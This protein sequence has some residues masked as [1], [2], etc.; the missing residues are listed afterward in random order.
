[1]SYE[2]KLGRVSQ[3]K[4]QVYTAEAVLSICQC[5]V[6]CK[7]SL[8]K[9][10]D[11]LQYH[12]VQYIRQGGNITAMLPFWHSERATLHNAALL[13]ITPTCSELYDVVN[14]SLHSWP[15]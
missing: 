12:I 14:V 11:L 1:M 15:T 6:R 2:F 13:T 4:I 8:G 9:S 5:P 3:H 7:H 10:Q